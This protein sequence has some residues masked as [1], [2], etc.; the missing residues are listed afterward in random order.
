[1][2]FFLNYRFKELMKNMKQ[3]SLDI[4]VSSQINFNLGYQS[5][6][7]SLFG[8]KGLTRF[9]LIVEVFKRFSHHYITNSKKV[10]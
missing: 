7:K 5:M 3:F 9:Q 8:F 10:L 6:I 1:M 4:K 2:T